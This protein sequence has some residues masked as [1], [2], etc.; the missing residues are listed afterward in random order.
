MTND[1]N[2]TINYQWEES[3]NSSFSSGSVTDIGA[4]SATYVVQQSDE[5]DYIRV[6][7]S[8]SDPSNPQSAATATSAAT[9]PI[10][11]DAALSVSTSVVSGAAVQIGQTLVSS[12]IITGDLSDLTAPVTYQWQ[13]SNDGGDDLV[14]RVGDHHRTI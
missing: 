8:T 13:V 2:A 6:V 14:G 7:A 10:I 12:A 11:D 9:G 3:T 1:P 4:D 5:N